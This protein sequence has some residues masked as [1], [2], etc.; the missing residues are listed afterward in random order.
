MADSSSFKQF[1]TRHSTFLPSAAPHTHIIKAQIFKTTSE[2]LS[3]WLQAIFLTFAFHRIP[4]HHLLAKAFL[5]VFL[6]SCSSLGRFSCHVPTVCSRHHCPFIL[7]LGLKPTLIS[8][9]TSGDFHICDTSVLPLP[10]LLRT[11]D[12]VCGF[13]PP[14]PVQN[15]LLASK[16]HVLHLCFS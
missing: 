1:W 7:M 5:H 10:P 16:D 13:M 2:P 3:I 4:A 8:R 6:W 15:E 9:M 14:S 12:C 11:H